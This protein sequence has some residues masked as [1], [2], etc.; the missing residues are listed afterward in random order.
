[1]LI[2]V[3]QKKFFKRYFKIFL[4]SSCGKDPFSENLGCGKIILPRKKS[5]TYHEIRKNPSKVFLYFQ[6][7]YDQLF[8]YEAS[9]EV[10]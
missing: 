3:S 9:K 5:V 1:M 8:P 6:D 4:K 7:T 10:R 2:V